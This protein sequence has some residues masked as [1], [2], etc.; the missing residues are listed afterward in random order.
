MKIRD[1]FITDQEV[2]NILADY[3]GQWAFWC[4]D[5]TICVNSEIGNWDTQIEIKTFCKYHKSVLHQKFKSLYR[6]GL[7]G[8]CDC[9]CRGDFEITDKRLAAIGRVRTKTYTGY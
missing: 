2:L 6:R 5:N 1:Y 4:D 3:Q 9:G 7:I 8:G